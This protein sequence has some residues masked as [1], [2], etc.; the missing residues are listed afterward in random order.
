ME[1]D[2]FL[3]ELLLVIIRL[4]KHLADVKTGLSDLHSKLYV[5]SKANLAHHNE[6]MRLSPS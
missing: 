1:N 2:I 6:N 5:N 4:N 3:M